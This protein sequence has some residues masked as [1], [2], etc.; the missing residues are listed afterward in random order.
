MRSKRC[1]VNQRE[2]KRR[3]LVIF[4][5]KRQMVLSIRLH[6]L[7]FTTDLTNINSDFNLGLQILVRKI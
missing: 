6:H 7:L 1:L 3:S 4:G 2:E 5:T